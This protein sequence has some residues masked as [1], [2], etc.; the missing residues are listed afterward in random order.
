VPRSASRPRPAPGAGPGRATWARIPDHRDR[1]RD[2]RCSRRAAPARGPDRGHSRRAAGA[3]APDDRARTLDHRAHIPDHRYSRRA[4]RARVPD[5]GH[6]RRAAGARNDRARIREGP[7]RPASR[8]GRRAAPG[9]AGVRPWKA[10][11]IGIA[12]ASCSS[13]I[14]RDERLRGAGPRPDVSRIWT[15]AAVAGMP[16]LRISRITGPRCRWAPAWVLAPATAPDRHC[17]R[18]SRSRVRNGLR[19][20]AQPGRRGAS[21]R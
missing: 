2:R 21:G 7:R 20:T 19:V 8:R 17:R 9:V 6:S 3:R 13:P 12:Y 16:A 1:S 5:H 11:P 4:A 18:W 15:R 10:S 14:Q